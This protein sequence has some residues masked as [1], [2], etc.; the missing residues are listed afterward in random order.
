M[1]L[2]YNFK[3]PAWQVVHD[4]E[5]STVKAMP[6]RYHSRLNSFPAGEVNLATADS[7]GSAPVLVKLASMGAATVR[8]S[9]VVQ[10]LDRVA[11]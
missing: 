8:L 4:S 11:W 9:F 2:S 5:V 10:G 6:Q 1:L 3:L 7:V